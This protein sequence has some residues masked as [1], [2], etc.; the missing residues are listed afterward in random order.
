[1]NKHMRLVASVLFI[2]VILLAVAI[3]KFYSDTSKNTSRSSAQTDIER[4]L[5]SDAAGNRIFE[6]SSGSYGVVDSDD[7]VIVSAEWLDLSFAGE[8]KCIAAKRISGKVMRGCVDYEGN[9]AV[10]FIYRSI[11]P[12]KGGSETLYIAESGI[13]SSF[14]VYDKDFAP[15][16]GRAWEE[17][18]ASG[19]NITLKGDEGTYRYEVRGEGFRL[20]EAELTCRALGCECTFS[21]KSPLLLERLD[22]DMIRYIVTAAGKYLEFAYTGDGSYISDVRTGGKPALTKL[23]PED[24]RI[25]EKKLLG[26]KEIYLY[27]SGS[28]NGVPLFSVSVSAET[29]LKYTAEGFDAPQTMRGD[30]R[31][32][33][34][35]SGTSAVDLTAYS[36]SFEMSEPEY[37]ALTPP[38][39]KKDPDGQDTP[40]PTDTPA[41]KPDGGDDGSG[42]KENDNYQGE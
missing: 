12:F 4:R 18:R 31:A 33:I 17:C 2:V 13:D 7:R 10:P 24:R 6:D 41:A 8:G 3:T 28:D 15:I 25:L 16:F 35:F 5:G 26:I 22:P 30:Y 34:R 23:F 14:V 11:T 27:S 21:V 29:E 9:V 1:L 40:E 37:L 36:G 32:F 42:D 19:S 20:A 38:E 39:K